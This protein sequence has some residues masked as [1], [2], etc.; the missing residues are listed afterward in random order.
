MNLPTEEQALQFVIM[1][2]AGLPAEHAILYFLDTDDTATI[3]LTLRKWQRSHAVSKAQRKLLGKSWQEMS[4]DEKCEAALDQA[5]AG[6][7]YFL[8]STNYTSA[9]QAEK[10]KLDTARQSLEQ[11]KAGTAGKVDPIWAFIDDYKKEKARK[12]VQ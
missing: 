2:Q 9:N 4:L 10:A 6:Q 7:A 5:Y 3:A 12:A 11:R 1:L 8:F